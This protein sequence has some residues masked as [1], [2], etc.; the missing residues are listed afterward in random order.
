MRTETLANAAYVI[1]LGI[2]KSVLS[3]NTVSSFGVYGRKFCLAGDI[4]SKTVL[5][6]IYLND[7][8]T[9][10]RS[11]VTIYAISLFVIVSRI[12]SENCK[13]KRFISCLTFAC[14]DV[15]SGDT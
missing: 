13:K 9:L 12:D 11:T 10:F 5:K 8:R 7:A 3:A 2:S 6:I 14:R 1:S 15:C 4:K